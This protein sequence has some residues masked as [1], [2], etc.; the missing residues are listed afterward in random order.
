MNGILDAPREVLQNLDGNFV[1]M[2]NSRNLSFCCGAG[3][4]QMWKEEEHGRATVY[5]TRYEQAT[6]T[7]ASTI[8]VACPF[9][10]TMLTDASKQADQGVAVKDIVELIAERIV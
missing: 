4:A 9:C 6:A 3:G 5:N 8:A 2:A 7:G 1:E 10:L